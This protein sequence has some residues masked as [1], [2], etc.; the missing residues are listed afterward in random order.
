MDK[1]KD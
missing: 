1:R